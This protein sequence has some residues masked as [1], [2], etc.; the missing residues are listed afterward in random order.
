M[1]FH[2][3]LLCIAVIL[4]VLSI[5]T[6][7]RARWIQPYYSIHV[8]ATGGSIWMG[9]IANRSAK[10]HVYSNGFASDLSLVKP[11]IDVAFGIK[12]VGP[13]AISISVP[14]ALLMII[15]SIAHNAYRLFSLRMHNRTSHPQCA[16]CCYDLSGAQL[17]RCP[18]CG[19]SI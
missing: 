12:R 18:E 10:P 13:G 17:S 4:F 19:A 15:V 5:C 11:T 1:K 16:K 6:A 3:V 8:E 7:F 14:F 2:Q 9:V